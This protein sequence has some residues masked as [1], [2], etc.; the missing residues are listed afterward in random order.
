MYKTALAALSLALSFGLGV[1]VSAQDSNQNSQGQGQSSSSGDSGNSGSGSGSNSNSGSG[2][3]SNK[4]STAA[5]TKQATPAAPAAPPPQYVQTYGKT[6]APTSVTKTTLTPAP[7]ASTTTTTTA[8]GAQQSTSTTTKTAS[9]G[10]SGTKDTAPAAPATGATTPS[11]RLKDE[12]VLLQESGAKKYVSAKNKQWQT[13]DNYINLK[14]GQESMPLTMTVTNENYT[15]INMLLNG[16]K[17]ATDKDFKGPTLRMQMT[18]ALAGGDNKL[19]IQAFGPVGANLTWRL[20]TL[21]PVISAIKPLTGAGE[22]DI[23]ITGKN[24]AKIASA[25]TVMVGTK[26]ATIK[27]GTSTSGKEIVFNLPKDMISGK[28][29]ITVSVGGILSKAVEFTVKAA[30]EVTGVDL[31]SAPPGQAMTI[32]GKG[33]SATQADNLVTIGGVPAPISS[34]NAT[35]ITITVPEMFY[36]QWHL[37]IVVKTGGIESKGNVQINIQMRVIPNDGVPEQ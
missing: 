9:I 30:P 22:D 32:T 2:S 31:I 1:A 6:A 16:Q 21:K 13:F 33:F 11:K 14:P 34:C 15:G 8:T 17:L 4:T 12:V 24:F 10:K 5:T 19:T 27:S 20:T 18:G 25:N 36:P 26:V 28:T 7:A 23:T 37:P 29:T 35:S 3:S